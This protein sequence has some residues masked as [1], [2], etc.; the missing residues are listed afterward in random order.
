MTNYILSIDQ[1]TNGSRAI[2]FNL[3]DRNKHSTQEEFSQHFP[4]MAELKVEHDP[5]DI[6][7]TVECTGKNVIAVIG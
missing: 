7:R 1:G 4:M 5:D 3:D 6:W 2:L